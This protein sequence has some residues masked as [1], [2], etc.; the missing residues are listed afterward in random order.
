MSRCELDDPATA[1]RT[2]K[3]MCSAREWYWEGGL[4]K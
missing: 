3:I 1:R 2:G 4:G